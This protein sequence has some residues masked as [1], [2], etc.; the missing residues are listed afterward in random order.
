MPPEDEYV[1]PHGECAEKIGKLRDR[2]K[3]LEGTIDGA[4]EYSEITLRALCLD[5]WG[6]DYAIPEG[7]APL[8]LRVVAAIRTWCNA[9]INEA[10]A[11]LGDEHEPG[12]GDHEQ[13]F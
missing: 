6:P 9:Q 1:D 5:L 8:L 11:E 13:K 7:A 3:E 4:A 10:L 12:D 2:I